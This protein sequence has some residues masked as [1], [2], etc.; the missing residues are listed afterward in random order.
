MNIM[1]K[2]V[3]A[4]AFAALTAL[5]FTSCNERKFHVEGNIENA[6]LGGSSLTSS[7]LFWSR[8]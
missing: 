6:T 5:G 4:F 8:V 1:T 7:S 2:K 3:A